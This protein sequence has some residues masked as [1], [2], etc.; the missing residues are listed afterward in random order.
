M[1]N[2]IKKYLK[3]IKSL[4]DLLKDIS[5]KHNEILLDDYFPKG[6]TLLELSPSPSWDTDLKQLI[7]YER[8]A[9][10]FGVKFTSSEDVTALINAIN[11][12]NRILQ[13]PDAP[14]NIKAL[15]QHYFNLRLKF[16]LDFDNKYITELFNRRN[17]IKKPY[18]LRG[19]YIFIE[20]YID[21]ELYRRYHKPEDDALEAKGID[22]LE[23]WDAQEEKLTPEERA[24]INA[25]ENNRRLALFKEYGEEELSNKITCPD[26]SASLP[27][28]LKENIK[29]FHDK[30]NKAIKALERAE[31]IKQ[32]EGLTDDE[33]IERLTQEEKDALKD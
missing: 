28:D 3:N 7:I 30:N 12:V 16:Y 13:D 9:K 23:Y 2:R 14:A 31:E 25:E 19:M 26:Y 6:D 22:P 21:S 10:D 15:E 4:E 24:K 8:H 20:N 5:R 18:L 29:R 11:A 17:E 27:E 1:K 32:K 33:A